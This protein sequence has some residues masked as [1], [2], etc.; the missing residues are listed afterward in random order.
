MAKD[1][2][3][4]KLALEEF[5]NDIVKDQQEQIQNLFNEYKEFLSKISFYSDNKIIATINIPIDI[6]F[7]KEKEKLR[8]QVYCKRILDNMLLEMS[9]SGVVNI[10]KEHRRL[11][12]VIYGTKFS[13][14]QELYIEPTT[15]LDIFYKK[16]IDIVDNNI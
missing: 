16:V 11:I 6:E 1:F 13:D 8:C 15:R 12:N 14:K 7:I 2:E 9:N 3:L 5:F 4:N 10:R